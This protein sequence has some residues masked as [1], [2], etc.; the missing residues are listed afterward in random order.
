MEPRL[1]SADPIGYDPDRQ[2]KLDWMLNHV[3]HTLSA[4]TLQRIRAENAA[5]G[6]TDDCL[7]LK[8]GPAGSQKY[9]RQ[10]KQD[11]QAYQSLRKRKRNGASR[12]GLE[13]RH[14]LGV[15]VTHRSAPTAV[16]RDTW[17]RRAVGHWCQ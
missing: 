5:L 16:K 8:Y 3:G 13:H 9:S 15:L 10:Q 4:P 17:Q 12:P 1:R 7:R 11:L 6:F 14:L 2:I